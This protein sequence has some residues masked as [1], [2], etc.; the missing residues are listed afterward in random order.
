MHIG[1]HGRATVKLFVDMSFP[2]SFQFQEG[3]R[4]YTMDCSRA[5]Q[6]GEGPSD[7]AHEAYG[8]AAV[9][10]GDIVIVEGLCE[11][12]GGFEMDG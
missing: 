8:A 9:D 6:F 10:Q 5:R 12:A 11:G 1:N 2:F 3:F 7:F 4:H